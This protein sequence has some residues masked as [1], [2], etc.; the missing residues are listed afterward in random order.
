MTHLIRPEQIIL[1]GDPPRRDVE[2]QK[3]RLLR[4]GQ[5]EP[6]L[7]LPDTRTCDTLGLYGNIHA[8][9][10]VCAAYELGW[11]SILVTDNPKVSG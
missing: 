6:V 3:E 10:I 11:E 7:L 8:E 9:A 2:Y 5:I 4:E 1:G